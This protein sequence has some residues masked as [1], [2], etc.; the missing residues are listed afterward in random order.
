MTLMYSP[1]SA[2][3]PPVELLSDPLTSR[4][5]LQEA[6][7]VQARLDAALTT[8]SVLLDMRG[9]IHFDQGDWALIVG[10]GFATLEINQQQVKPSPHARVV[11]ASDV[12]SSKLQLVLN[13]DTWPHGNVKVIATRLFFSL[14]DCS[15]MGLE[16]PDYGLASSDAIR[17][18][19]PAWDSP[20]AHVIG[21]SSRIAD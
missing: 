16:R 3:G 12:V 10:C 7:L 4:D 20:R 17:L 8:A 19:R 15:L 9:A 1:S 5:L 11:M 2:F 18:S 21:T 13:I 14:L 6:E